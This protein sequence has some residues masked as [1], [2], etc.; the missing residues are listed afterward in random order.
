MLALFTI[1]PGGHG[2]IVVVIEFICSHQPG[3]YSTGSVEM[4][5]LGNVEFAVPHPIPDAA[6]LQDGQPSNVCFSIFLGNPSSRLADDNR[7]LSLVVELFGFRWS[8]N[9]LPVPHQ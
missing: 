7:D 1:D 8:P 2:Q 6:F 3:S 5:A 4:L 9:R